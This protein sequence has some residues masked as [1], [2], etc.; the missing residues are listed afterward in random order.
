LELVQQCVHSLFDLLR[1]LGCSNVFR[2]KQL[3][4]YV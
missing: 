2:K 3:S 1:G 4:C